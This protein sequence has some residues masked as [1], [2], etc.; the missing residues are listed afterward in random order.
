[1]SQNIAKDTSFSELFSQL[2]ESLNG[3]KTKSF[4][5]IRKRAIALLEKVKFPDRHDENWKYTSVKP[6]LDLEF[7]VAEKLELKDTGIDF[8]GVVKIPVINGIPQGEIHQKSMIIKGGVEIMTIENAMEDSRF[9]SRLASDTEVILENKTAFSILNQAFHR[10]GI[11]IYVPKGVKAENSIH[12]AHISGGDLNSAIIST[13]IVAIVEEGGEVEII[14]SFENKVY[15]QKE[16]FINGLNRFYID[17]NARL[18]HYKLQLESDKAFQITNSTAYQ[19]RDSVFTSH[20][21]DAGGKVVRN[22]LN[23]ILEGSGTNSNLFGVYYSNG[24]RHIDNQTFIDHALPHCQSNE[25]YKGVLTERG[26]GVFNG[27]VMV[28]QDAQKTNAYQQNSSLVLS[29]YASMNAKPQLEIFADDVKCS[30]GATIGQLSEESIF[31]LK[32][33]GI[34]EAEAKRLL[35]RAFIGEVLEKMD[36]E[37]IREFAENLIG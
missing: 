23:V 24:D 1:M 25:L 27:K 20:V 32:S 17:Q 33:R 35:Q 19:K 37:E 34:Q 10:G 13:Q 2:E 4:H 30:H 5:Q 12:L 21:V 8:T 7:K 36:N 9:S 6:I 3:Q 31:Y 26:R 22:N 28:R 18:T 16:Y 15:P 14:E 11:F 29:D